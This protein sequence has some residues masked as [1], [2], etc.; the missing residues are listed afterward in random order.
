LAVL[1]EAFYSWGNYKEFFFVDSLAFNN[2]GL[3]DTVMEAK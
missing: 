2:K 1:Y 3:G